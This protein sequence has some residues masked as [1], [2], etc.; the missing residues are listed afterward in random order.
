MIKRIAKGTYVLCRCKHLKMWKEG[1]DGCQECIHEEVVM[2]N[3]GLNPRHE[4]VKTPDPLGTLRPG[5]RVTKNSKYYIPG[6]GFIK[7][8]DAF[9]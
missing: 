4:L 9:I 7:K 1:E 6:K 5:V 8:E 2:H 3:V